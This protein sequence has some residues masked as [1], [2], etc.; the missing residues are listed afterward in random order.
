LVVQDIRDAGKAM[1]RKSVRR[2]DS[3][4]TDDVRLRFWFAKAAESLPFGHLSWRSDTGTTRCPIVHVVLEVDRLCSSQPFWV[5]VAHLIFNPMR[6]TSRKGKVHEL[7]ADNDIFAVPQGVRPHLGDD[8]GRTHVR[9]MFVVQ[10]PGAVLEFP[11]AMLD[12]WSGVCVDTG[13]R[14]SSLLIRVLHAAV[15]GSMVVKRLGAHHAGVPF[16]GLFGRAGI[17]DSLWFRQN[18]AQST[19]AVDGD[20]RDVASLGLVDELI[21]PGGLKQSTVP[22]SPF[23]AP[24]HLGGFAILACGTLKDAAVGFF[25]VVVNDGRDMA[26]GALQD[27]RVGQSLWQDA[28]STAGVDDGCDMAR[29]TLQDV[30][31]GQLLWQ[32]ALSTDQGT[33]FMGVDN[34]RD[35]ARGTLQDAAVGQ[36]LWQGALLTD[37]GA[38]FRAMIATLHAAAHWKTLQLA[39]SFGRMPCLAIDCGTLDA[40]P[41]W[42]AVLW[43]FWHVTWHAATWGTR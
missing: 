38:S 40:L 18:Q 23:D 37:Q 15:I 42:H 1:R 34:G 24:G 5:I 20:V 17:F 28:F 11:D 36:W 26:C 3:T 19:V 35:M 12:A 29:G 32:G 27:A 8:D 41:Y 43:G 9:V 14:N 39:S 33:S 30:V 13:D 10:R 21:G 4:G 2:R 16:E 7:G 6:R 31:V 25:T 22:R